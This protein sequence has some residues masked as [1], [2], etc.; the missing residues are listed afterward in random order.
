[1]IVWKSWDPSITESKTAIV[2]KAI[3]NIIKNSENNDYKRGLIRNQNW[4]ERRQKIIER[5]K[6]SCGAQSPIN[7]ITAP[8]H[9]PR[10]RPNTIRKKGD[11]KNE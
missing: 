11:E 3:H 5:T 9:N 7:E 6:S 4:R 2:D 1:M 8:C 10:Y